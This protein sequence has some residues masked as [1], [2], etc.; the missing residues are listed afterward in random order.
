MRVLCSK[1]PHK[2]F[3]EG[4]GVQKSIFFFFGHMYQ[5]FSKLTPHGV[6]V[7]KTIQ[8]Y[9]LNINIIICIAAKIII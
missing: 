1:K 5:K 8:E 9:F 2:I 4:L 3:S 6:N 7:Y